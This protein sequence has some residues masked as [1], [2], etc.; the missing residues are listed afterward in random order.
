MTSG[1]SIPLPPELVEALTD[2]IAEKLSE[3]MAPPIEPFITAEEAAEHIA[4]PKSRIYELKEQERIGYYMDGRN[5]RFKRS[6]LD[7]YMAR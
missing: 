7:A 2:Q 3:R 6:D 5:V 4:S 1:W